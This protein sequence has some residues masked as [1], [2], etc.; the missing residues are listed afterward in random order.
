MSIPG[1]ESPDWLRTFKPQGSTLSVMHLSSDSEASGDHSLGEDR[2]T[3]D[4]PVSEDMVV[5][6]DHKEFSVKKASKKMQSPNKR[7]KSAKLISEKKTTEDRPSKPGMENDPKAVGKEEECTENNAQS[8]WA[9]SSDSETHDSPVRGAGTSKSP[10]VELKVEETVAVNKKKTTNKVTEKVIGND[11]DPAVAVEEITGKHNKSDALVECEDDSIDISGD[12]GAVGRVV[13]SNSSSRNHE[14]LLDMK[15]T[16]YKTTIVPSR[17]FCVVSFGQS[18]AKIEAIM[19]DFIQLKP[20]SNVYEAETMVEGTLEGFSFDSG[21]ESD[22]V[23]KAVPDQNE[24]TE[25]QQTNKKSRT[26]A[27]KPSA[28]GPPKKRAKTTG[29]PVK[30]VKKKTQAST[31]KG[32]K[33]KK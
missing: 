26:K 1:D 15:G 3:D 29:K 12:V 30:K 16:M 11:D 5:A 17:T 7:A 18:E 9:L 22:R 33:S 24:E 4:K 10:K 20:Q 2:S 13:I 23:P 14:M 27:E 21:D 32:G 25:K 6:D 28:G 19:N 31:K 8:I